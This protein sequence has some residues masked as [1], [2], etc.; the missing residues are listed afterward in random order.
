MDFSLLVYF[1]FLEAMLKKVTFG[2]ISF[3]PN[4]SHIFCNL[5]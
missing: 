3:T 2:A 4:K 1:V 5:T